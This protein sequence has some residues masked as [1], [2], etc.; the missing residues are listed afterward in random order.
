MANVYD[1]A[2]Y[3]KP[4]YDIVALGVLTLLACSQGF[5]EKPFAACS[6][7]VVAH[8]SA[9]EI[10]KARLA[11]RDAYGQ[12]LLADLPDFLNHN[13]ICAQRTVYDE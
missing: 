11:G 12:I 5:V 10:G 7:S 2:T 13:A 6:R 3:C 4:R 8:W 9:N 1:I